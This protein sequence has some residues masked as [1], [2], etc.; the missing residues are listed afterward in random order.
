MFILLDIDGVLVPAKNWQ[1]I[2]SK[3][4]G[5]I[6]FSPRAVSCLNELLNETHASIVLS[7]SHKNRFTTKQW[8]KIFQNRGVN[9][10]TIEILKTKK[11]D[12]RLEEILDWYSKSN[13]SAEDFIIIDDDKRLNDLPN[14]LK[15]RLVLT[16]SFV[17][18]NK[19]SLDEALRLLP[20]V[21]H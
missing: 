21:H 9:A 3:D 11:V 1:T 15:E 16:K 4:D 12:N 7:T 6:E 18:F 8:V 5:F 13:N 10:T 2:D 20:V 19:E 17:G 14:H